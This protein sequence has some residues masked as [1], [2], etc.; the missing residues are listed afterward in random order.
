MVD[1]RRAD[2]DVDL[3]RAGLAQQLDD[4]LGRRPAHDRIVDDDEPLAV[5][6]LA[7]RVELDRH[8]AMAQ[9]GRRLDERPPGVPVAVHPLA[10]RQAGRLGEAGRGG[11]AGVGDGHHQVGID[12]V[13]H[14][15]L[16][17]HLATGLV[18][19]AALHVR[20]RPG[21]VDELEDAQRGRRVGETD[22]A[23]RLAR[24]EDDHLAGLDVADVLGADDVEGRRLRREAPAGLGVVAVPQ[25][26]VDIS[27][28]RARQPTEDQRTET[29]RIAHADDP[30][31]VEDHQA[32]RATHAR[33]DALEGLD[34]IGGRLVGQERGQ[35]LRVGRGGQA[36]ATAP[37]LLEQV[38]GVDEVAVVADGQRTPRT[39]P[40]RR[41]GVLPDGG[42]RCR[43]AA[44]GDRELAPETRQASLVE[45]VADHPEVL[46]EHQLLAVADRQP[47][48]FLAAML[49]R[50]Q[51]ERRDRG[52]L[53]R[54]ATRQDHAEDAAHAVSP[55]SRGHGRG[56]DPRHDGGPAAGP[57]AH[58]RRH[59]RGPRRSRSRRP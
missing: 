25:A 23:R 2:P 13:L 43:I 34:G 55:P 11:G 26:V 49:E 30:A 45:D 6:D 36:G 31:L 38:A 16:H 10:V 42:T 44:M 52:G 48:Q 3:G 18:Q 27:G 58:R 46:V 53:G 8:A 33:E 50:E 1:R 21:E 56:R 57:R 54:L 40:V 14:R 15:Q 17:A 28:G 9:P 47:G 29:E 32:V 51:A 7:Q 24:L 35:Q 37:E 22:R 59:R 39:E 19:V 20:V 41:L 12:R 4:P 5:D